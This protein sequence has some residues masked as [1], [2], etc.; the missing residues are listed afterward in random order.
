MASLKLKFK[1]SSKQSKEGT[2]YYQIIHQRVVRLIKTNYHLFCMN[3][4]K[5]IDA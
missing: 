4:M 5:P 1:T 2:L 3:G